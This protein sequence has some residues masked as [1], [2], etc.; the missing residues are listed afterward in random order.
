MRSEWFC[1]WGRLGIITAMAAG[2]LL[3]C[4]GNQASN[5]DSGSGNDAGH[6]T[7]AG[8]DGG[9]CT[10]TPVGEC[11]PNACATGNSKNV[12]A[13][14]TKGGGQ[15]SAYSTGVACAI[16]LSTSGANFCILL[17][18]H[19]NAD[20][21]EQA[22]CTGDPTGPPIYACVPLTCLVDAGDPCPPPP[23]RSDAGRSDGGDGG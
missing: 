18:C 10:P 22:C 1:D 7:D 9:S 19:Q 14:C 3:G 2:A 15:C 20:C 11:F 6:T 13:Y 4:S 16:D 17:G 12:G 8:Q 5:S 21:G 23:S